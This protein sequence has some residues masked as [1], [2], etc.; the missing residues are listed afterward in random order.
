MNTIRAPRTG[1]E[2]MEV[3]DTLPGPWCKLCEC[4]IA[5]NILG[6]R[7]VASR[8]LSTGALALAWRKSWSNI[9]LLRVSCCP[10]YI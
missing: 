10:Y 8:T 5:L 3:P 7:L 2:A 9:P 6:V 1:A 4:S